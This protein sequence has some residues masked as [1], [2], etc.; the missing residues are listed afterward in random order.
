M[1]RLTF[2]DLFC[3][4][5]AFH[6][7]FK[8]FTCVFACDIDPGIQAIYNANYGMDVHGDIRT[9]DPN[10]LPSFDIL[11]AGFPCQPFSIAGNGAGFQD[12][13]RGTLFADILRI[14]DVKL[15]RM[16]ILENVKNL[17]THDGGRTYATIEQSLV[18][19]GYT[20][21]SKVLTAS[22]YGSPQARQRIFLVATRGPPFA[23]PEGTGPVVP[24]ASILDPTVTHSDL[25]CAKYDLVAVESPR[26]DLAKPSLLFN[27]VDK[28]TRKGGRQGERVYDPAHVGITV[29]ASSGGPGAKTGLYKVGDT[30]RR[31]TVSETLGMFGFPSTYAFGT[32]PSERALFYLGNSIVVNVIAAFAP[33]ITDW[34]TEHAEFHPERI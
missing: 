32:L 19:R 33:A 5:G 13:E 17:K 23:I 14:L 29:C 9:V 21:V 20:V 2:A 28:T 34:F 7:A 11:C 8:D 31:L 12:A 30:I 16:C 4:L 1:A 15:P 25:N 6:T 18:T 10:T 3:G 27:V 26:A 24:V 22:D